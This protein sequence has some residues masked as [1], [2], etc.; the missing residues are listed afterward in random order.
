MWFKINKGSLDQ[1]D[2]PLACPEIAFNKST[3]LLAL[4]VP[5]PVATDA[6]RFLQGLAMSTFQVVLLPTIVGGEAC[7]LLKQD[8]SVY[9]FESC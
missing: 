3:V 6:A 5:P 2:Q 8:P 7:C 4:A 1:S 9:S